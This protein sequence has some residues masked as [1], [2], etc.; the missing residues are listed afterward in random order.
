MVFL[1]ECVDFVGERKDQLWEL[2]EPIDGPLVS[3]YCKLA[4]EHKLWLSLGSIHVRPEN[5]DGETTPSTKIR[6]THVLI[7][8]KGQVAATYDKLHLFDIDIPSFR[9]KES[10]FALKGNQLT[11]P[12]ETPVGQ[13]GMGICYDMRFPEM[14]LALMKAG[15]HIITFPSAFTISTGYSHWESLLRARAIETQC[16]IVAAAQVGQHNPKRSSYGHSMVRELDIFFSSI[17]IC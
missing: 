14:A 4:S 12:V 16:Y 5:P 13:V 15:A 7:N 6:N 9:I 8:C 1:P 17:G 3:A 2:A 10:D 11:L